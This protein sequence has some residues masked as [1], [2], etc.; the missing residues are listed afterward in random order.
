MQGKFWIVA[1]AGLVASVPASAN[2]GKAYV[3]ADAGVL[4]PKGVTLAVGATENAARITSNAGWDGDLLIGYDFGRFRLEGEASLKTSSTQQLLAEDAA[5]VDPVS[6]GDQSMASVSGDLKAKSF[7]LN[8]LFD[9]GKDDGIFLYAGAGV[10][11]GSAR[12][13]SKIFGVSTPLLDDK[14]KGLAWQLVAGVSVPV[15]D[16]IEIGA[17]YRYFNIEGLDFDSAIAD[18]V[19]SNFR[20]HSLLTSLRINFGS[21]NR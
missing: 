21:A 4:L 16:N 14:A 10:G 19:S 20:S 7:M 9:A 5:D 6:P 8:A 11:F 12:Y 17:K 2:D 13:E 1:L 15:T 3:G 18:R